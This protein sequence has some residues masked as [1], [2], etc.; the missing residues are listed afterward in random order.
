MR[1]QVFAERLHVVGLSL[2][3]PPVLVKHLLSGVC[4]VLLAGLCFLLYW[5]PE[6]QASSSHVASGPFLA[7]S[8]LALRSWYP[9]LEFGLNYRGYYD[10]E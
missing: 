5:A 10:L 2:V 7:P 9:S 3:L 8:F 1:Q 4:E 6:P